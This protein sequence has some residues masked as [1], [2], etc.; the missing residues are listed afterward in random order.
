MQLLA[1]AKDRL[2]YQEYI[3]ARKVL[4]KNLLTLYLA[5]QKK[6]RLKVSPRRKR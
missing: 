6:D 3:E 2:G 4:D 5:L 1:I